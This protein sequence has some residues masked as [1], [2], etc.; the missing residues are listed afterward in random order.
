MKRVEIQERSMYN[1]VIN[2]GKYSRVMADKRS[3]Y[4]GIYRGGGVSKVLEGWVLGDHVYYYD[5]DDDQL[6]CTKI[7][8]RDAIKV[9]EKKIKTAKY[10]L[11]DLEFNIKLQSKHLIGLEEQLEE[12]LEKQNKRLH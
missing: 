11:L 4:A 2:V 3:F 7:V 12:L 9:L 6:Y 5:I 1:Q 10:V 8:R